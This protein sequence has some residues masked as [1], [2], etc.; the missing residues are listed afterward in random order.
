MSNFNY[1]LFLLS[2]MV[3][4]LKICLFSLISL[5]LSLSFLPIFYPSPPKHCFAQSITTYTHTHTHTHIHIHTHT[6]TNT[7][8]Q[9]HF[10]G[11]Y[12]PTHKISESCATPRIYLLRDSRIFPTV[13]RITVLWLVRFMP[14]RCDKTDFLGSRWLVQILGVAWLSGGNLDWF[15]CG[16]CRMEREKAG[17]RTVR[18]IFRERNLKYKLTNEFDKW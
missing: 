3:D 4:L 11:F 16:L 2:T 8:S 5:S 14:P 10:P 1:F 7:Y 17:E 13:A 9:N 18:G 6:N 15:F 12:S